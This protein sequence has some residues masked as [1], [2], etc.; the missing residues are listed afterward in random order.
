MNDLGVF[1]ATIG[2]NSAGNQRIDVV[3]TIKNSEFETFG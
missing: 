3:C 1:S 2:A